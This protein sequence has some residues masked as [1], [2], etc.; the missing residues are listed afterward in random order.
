[1]SALLFFEQVVD[2]QVG[3]LVST[4]F[5]QSH[6][7]HR[8]Q[9]IRDDIMPHFHL[10]MQTTEADWRNKAVELNCPITEGCYAVNIEQ[11]VSGAAERL[12]EEASAYFHLTMTG[13]YPAG[14]WNSK[15]K[16][17]PLSNTLLLGSNRMIQRNSTV[18]KSFKLQ[19]D[20]AQHGT[21]L[22]L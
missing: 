5:T 13:R 20:T 14:S 9:R 12:A 10:I 1:M 4:L 2:Q 3:R 15:D 19:H 6:V 8:A 7:S 18:Q 16:T 11:E 17:F 21:V 22:W